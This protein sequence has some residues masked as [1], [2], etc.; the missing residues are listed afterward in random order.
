M[1]LDKKLYL[2][3]ASLEAEKDAIEAKQKALK[4]KILE[5][6]RALPE[7]KNGVEVNQGSFTLQHKVTYKYSKSTETAAINLKNRQ[8]EE[9]AKG[10]AKINTSTEYVVYRPVQAVAES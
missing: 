9:V 5:E 2:E 7:G 8:K 1:A 6:L 10:I 4:A 3:Y